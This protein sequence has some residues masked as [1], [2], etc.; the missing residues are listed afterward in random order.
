MI[1]IDLSPTGYDLI[2]AKRAKMTPAQLKR[3]GQQQ[4]KIA[5]LPVWIRH[6]A[7]GTK[8][9]ALLL[10][11]QVCQDYGIEEPVI[12]KW[13]ISLHEA[14]LGEALGDGGQEQR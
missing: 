1:T 5:L 12:V 9:R 7:P 6:Y 13:L 3:E 10:A 8:H 2:R 11:R 4:L 14:A